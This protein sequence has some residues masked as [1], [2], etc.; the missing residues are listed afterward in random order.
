MNDDQLITVVRDSFADV[1]LNVPLERTT[2]RG[3]AL[4]GRALGARVA[5][6][7]AVA[8]IATVTSIAVSTP[9]GTTLAAWTVTKGANG[10]VTF[11]IRQLQGTA[12]LGNALRAAGVPARVGVLTGMPSTSPT[13]LPAG[14]RDVRMSDVANA[15]LQEKILG[16]PQDNMSAWRHGIGMTIRTR[17]I[18]PGVGIYLGIQPLSNGHWGWEFDLVQATTSCTG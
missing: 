3:R 1:R 9:S 6:V 5:A 15:N 16:G 18:P 11:T 17:E 2:R 7:A 4:R 13:D 14:C 12:G 8:A 10:D